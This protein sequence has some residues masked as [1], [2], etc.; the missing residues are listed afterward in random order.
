MPDNSKMKSVVILLSA[1]F[2]MV[3]GAIALIIYLG[4]SNPE[5]SDPDRVGGEFTLQSSRGPVSLSQ[6]R[7][8]VVLLFFGYTHCPDVCPTTMNNVAEAMSQL[9]NNEQSR[10]QPLFITVD[11]QR[12]TVKHLAEYVGF[13]HPKIIGLSGS[14]ADIKRV[15][16]RYSVQFFKDKTEE[17]KDGYLVSH[18]SYLFLINANGEVVDMM[19]DHTS[20]IDI[21][22]TVRQLIPSLGNSE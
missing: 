5:Q 9:K 21:A 1:I 11:P 15:S 13:F 4:D 8:Q 14:D 10:V 6:F 18:T 20:P 2:L 17:I 22:K 7:G 16:E 19:S 3:A 12:D